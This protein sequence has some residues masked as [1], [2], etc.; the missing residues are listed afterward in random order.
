MG[1]GDARGRSFHDGSEDTTSGAVN[2]GY[3]F[4]EQWNR[5]LELDPPFVMVTGWNEW[6]AR[7]FQPTRQSRGVR[8][9]VQ[10]GIQPGHRADER[11]AR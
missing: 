6:I 1:D 2:H 7:R 5:A 9:P 8:R 3:N 11:R 10:R 4:A